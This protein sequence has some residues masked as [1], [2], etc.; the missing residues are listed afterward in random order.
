MADIR[1]C[2]V[3]GISLVCV[4]AL[5]TGC[6][7]SPYTAQKKNDVPGLVAMA[8]DTEANLER[9]REPA[10]QALGELGTQ[11]AKDALISWLENGAPPDLEE[12]VY[13]AAGATGDLRAVDPLLAALESIDRDK[14]EYEIEPGDQLKL[15]AVIDGLRGLV[16]P[17][18]QKA[19]LAELDAGHSEVID[20]VNLSAALAAQGEAIAP[21]LE[22]RLA[23]ADDKVFVPAAEALGDIYQAAG[24]QDRAAQLLK[25]K[26]T[27]RIYAGI[28]TGDVV[29]DDQL[30]IDSL[31]SVGDA[32]MAQ[33]LL[34]TG[35]AELEAAA[36]AWAA[37]HG[38]T[39]ETWI[40]P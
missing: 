24:K 6:L 17:R 29:V 10:V 40:T 37:K 8:E 15:W 36:K 4:L 25:D 19:L 1:R 39:I 27:F 34:N 30:V 18:V 23:N 28:I 20:D 32:M 38:Y 5:S 16:D 31:N 3:L 11:E 35:S 9:V 2:F 12:A 21:E 22:K 26:K 14:T 7:V 13:R 33:R